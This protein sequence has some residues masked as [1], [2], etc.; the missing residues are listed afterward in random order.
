MQSSTSHLSFSSSNS[1][2]LSTGPSGTGS[3]WSAC[4]GDTG[5]GGVP[6]TDQATFPDSLCGAYDVEEKGGDPRTVQASL[7]AQMLVGM[8]R[9]LI[10]LS[11]GERGG[12]R[13]GCNPNCNNFCISCP[14]SCSRSFSPFSVMDQ[15]FATNYRALRKI[16]SF[17]MDCRVV[18]DCR[19]QEMLWVMRIRKQ[20]FMNS[21]SDSADTAFSRVFYDDEK[22]EGV[23]QSD[24]R[25]QNLPTS[26]TSSELSAHQMGGA[27]AGT[28]RLK[29]E[30]RVAI[31][32]QASFL[33]L[34]LS[35]FS[36]PFALCEP[37][38]LSS[39]L[40][41]VVSYGTRCSFF[42]CGLTFVYFSV[43]FFLFARFQRLQL[44]LRYF[45]SDK[46]GVQ[47][48]IGEEYAHIRRSE[49]DLGSEVVFW[50]DDELT[51]L[52]SLTY[53]TTH[54]FQFTFAGSEQYWHPS[55]LFTLTFFRTPAQ[56]VCHGG[57]QGL[58]EPVAPMPLMHQGIWILHTVSSSSV[59][60]LTSAWTSLS[61]F[62]AAVG[63]RMV[64]LEYCQ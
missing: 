31:L 22:S 27:L 34:V 61:R 9:Y 44:F 21:S 54:L 1:T 55:W 36:L 48:N 62:P 64:F 6:K 43:Y 20:K 39:F 14:E 17:A 33:K 56:G 45:V 32:A 15:N 12:G 29:S 46:F 30:P 7:C 24:S 41:Y 10:S 23:R 26:V 59:F 49:E 4:A 25:V 5:T 8:G 42:F 58:S 47:A 19:V 38:R 63:R 53:M 37:P 16:Q 50:M 3:G 51:G 2:L 60:Q 57:P 18:M 35:T 40:R 28:F 11:P 13:G 52:M